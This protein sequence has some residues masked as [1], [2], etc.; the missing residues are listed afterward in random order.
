V[1]EPLGI[2]IRPSCAPEVRPL[3]REVLRPGQ[4]DERLRFHG[5][6]DPFTLHL[7]ALREGRIVAVASVMPEGM[8]AGP[9]PGDWRIRGMASAPAVRGQGIGSAMLERCVEHAKEHGG[10]R[11]WCN[12]RVGARSLYERAGLRVRGER[13]ELPGIGEH[14]LMAMVIDS[15]A[16]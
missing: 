12:A 6:D 5:D 1:R 11:I 14:H 9:R 3:R 10:S 15:A 16:P 2:E 8:P 13:F 7:A 4:S